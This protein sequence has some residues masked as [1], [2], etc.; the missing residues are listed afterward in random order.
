MKTIFITIFQGVEAKNLLR[1]NVYRAF[2]ADPEIE[3][4]L[5]VRTPE[6]K[7]YYEAEFAHPRVHF[8]M[9]HYELC[10]FWDALFGKL[11]FLLLRT[12]TTDL[13]RRM[14]LDGDRNYL[15]FA[16]S[17]LANRV[18]AR[19][20]V[21]RAVRVLDR[22]L[23]RDRAFAPFFEK[24]RPAAV[25]LAHL[26][27]DEETALLR[28]ATRRRTPTVGFINSWDKMTAR[29]TLRL[30]PD[31]LLVFNE[32]VREEAMRHADVPGAR[33]T[34]VGLPQYDR[35]VGYH[36]VA[37][38]EFLKNAGF[39]PEDRVLLYAPMGETFSTADWDIID[40]LHAWELSGLLPG[41]LRSFVRFQP[42]DTVND[43]ELGRR[44][45]LRFDRPGK[46]FSRLRGVDWD[47]DD[48]ELK[49]L[50]D[51][52]AHA[53]LLVCY[54]SSIS[55]DAAVFDKPVI[56]ID[57]ELRPHE[58][59]ARSPTQFYQ[60]SHYRNALR[61]GGIRLARSKEDLLE[62]IR[63]YAENPA[64]DREARQRLVREQCGIMDGNA[65]E[66]LARAVL[67]KARSGGDL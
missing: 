25:L 6:R 42:N 36:P 19:P 52:L 44:P 67:R 2:I 39:L 31:T 32:I 59:L 23:V 57:F 64:R 16:V 43:D 48:A 60:M 7:A 41:R 49:H 38:S 50:A 11:K 1:T 34:A 37:R 3:L 45:W 24:Y 14:K 17:W 55:I 47:M 4:V 61:T 26:F 29:C 9:M 22:L 33:I 54:A 35:Y 12:E 53:D 10:G 28:E 18:L 30:H 65:G 40:L 15:S 58:R 56:N 21:R 63:T 20:V 13:R 27:D 5:F 8:E 46:R 51:T 62:A 66:R